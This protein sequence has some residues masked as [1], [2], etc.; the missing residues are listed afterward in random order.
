MKGI[1]KATVSGRC[2]SQ[3][4]LPGEPF[5]GTIQVEYR[6]ECMYFGWRIHDEDGEFLGEHW[7]PVS[8]RVIPEGDDPF[9]YALSLALEGMRRYRIGRKRAFLVENVKWK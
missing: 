9:E 3:T 8:L 1:R 6:D 2:L 7:R 4:G 5:H